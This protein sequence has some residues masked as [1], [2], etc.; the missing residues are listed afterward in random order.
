MCS[1]CQDGL[2]DPSACDEL[3]EPLETTC[4]HRFHAA[5]YARFMETS[6]RDPVCPMCRTGQIS[7]RFPGRAGGA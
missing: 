5:C 7:V 6:E 1:I 4:G 2:E 3:G